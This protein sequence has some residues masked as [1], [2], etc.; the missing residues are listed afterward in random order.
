[1][2]L[3]EKDKQHFLDGDMDWF[4]SP[5]DREKYWIDILKNQEDAKDKEI[6][7]QRVRELENQLLADN[8]MKEDAEKYREEKKLLE[9]VDMN[10][11]TKRKENNE[12]IV[13]RL[14]KLLEGRTDD[15][16]FTGRYL[17][18]EVLGEKK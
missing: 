15:F 10:E 3:T 13:E 12:K 5:D 16:T 4:G 14:K 9:G 7:L 1:M 18:K 2:K 11:F 6:C 17:R 8:K